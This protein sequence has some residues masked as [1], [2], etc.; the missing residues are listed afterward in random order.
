MPCT[1]ETPCGLLLPDR[2][3]SAVERA[4]LQHLG[5]AFDYCRSCGRRFPVGLTYAPDI[6]EAPQGRCPTHGYPRPC[7]GCVEDMRQKRRKIA[8]ASILCACGCEAPV[9]PGRTKYASEACAH[10]Q[11]TLVT[12]KALTRTELLQQRELQRVGLY[13]G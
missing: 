12:G 9:P 10:G 11:R 5:L 2:P 3:V 8:P 13:R 4:E 7:G 6:T 1:R